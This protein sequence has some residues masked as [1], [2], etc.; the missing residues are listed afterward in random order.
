M[1]RLRRAGFTLIELLVVVAIIALLISIL[2]P[3]LGSA[4][5]QAKSVKCLANLRQI[6][7]AMSRYLLDNNEW[8]PHGKDNRGNVL[9]GV[10]YGG[11]PGRPLP[12]GDGIYDNPVL[13]DTPNGRPFNSYLYSGLPDYDVEP[14]DPHFEIVRNLPTFS[15]PSD[16]G[17][18]A[19]NAEN[20]DDVGRK[21]MYWEWGTSYDAN[22]QMCRYWAM[23]YRYPNPPP[24]FPWQNV[25]NAL[26]KIQ[27][28][29]FGS[30]FVIIYEDP[31]DRSVFMGMP[32]R[33][34][35][36]KMNR[37]N[38][39]FLDGHAANMETDTVKGDAGV[40]W[41]TCTGSQGVHGYTPWW[42]DAQSPD[43]QY[44]DIPPLA[45]E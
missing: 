26:L 31:F 8:F 27:L 18:L 7:N 34:W 12:N 35:H 22:W 44:R 36:K 5:E 9:T 21:P 4:R 33:G 11:H 28:L 32:M 40:G 23:E 10:Y 30:I 6:G 1:F 25:A 20:V 41:K 42:E 13:R 15:C 17:G 2:L 24:T 37:H 39:L 43:Y 38:L 29:K 45:G 16:G 14:N 19:M 3:S